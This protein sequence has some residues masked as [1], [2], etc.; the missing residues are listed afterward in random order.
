MLFQKAS[1]KILLY[2]MA[3]G[4]TVASAKQSRRLSAEHGWPH[5]YCVHPCTHAISLHRRTTSNGFPGNANPEGSGDT[6]HKHSPRS[7]APRLN[8]TTYSLFTHVPSGKMSSGVESAGMRQMEQGGLGAG[9]V[10]DVL[11][12]HCPL[13]QEI[14]AQ[15]MATATQNPRHSPAGNRAQREEAAHWGRA[16]APACGVPPAC[17]PWPAPEAGRN[18]NELRVRLNQTRNQ[19]PV[20]RGGPMGSA[21]RWRSIWRSGKSTWHSTWHPT[22]PRNRI[23]PALDGNSSVPTTHLCA[24][25][26]QAAQGGQVSALQHAHPAGVQLHDGCGVGE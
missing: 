24:V 22:A 26:P 2:L 11:T 10:Q 8:M 5:M 23:P 12:S 17:D 20:S 3:M 7:N 16:R 19:S 1:T 13:G 14:T 15:N 6:A 25:E 4:H 18:C 21:L 9:D